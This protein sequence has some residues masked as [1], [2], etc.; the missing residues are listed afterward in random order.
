MY[1]IGYRRHF[2]R[3][4]EWSDGGT[5]ERI[6]RM[7]RVGPRLDRLVLRTPFQRACFRFV[8]ST[9]L[10]S[11]AHRLVL[12]AVIGLALVLASQALMQSFDTAKSLKQLVLSPGVLS[13]PFI[14]TFL[15]ILGLRIV[16]E[17]PVELR[18]NWIFQLMVDAD[19]QESQPLAQKTILLAVLPW[20][21]SI[22]FAS[23]VYLAGIEVALLH[24]MLVLTWAALLTNIA[25]IRF[26]KLPFTC[27]L[28]VFKQHSIVILV[29]LCFGYL[30][31][32]VTTPELESSALAQPLRMLVFLPVALV[33][34]SIPHYL[35]KNTIEIDRKLIFEESATRTVEVLRLSE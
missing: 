35:G 10:R 19:K 6:Y 33:A 13:I 2:V 30:L 11:E 28:P 24:T 25:L 21:L 7:S 23:Y 15:L 27:T 18:S 17:I 1:A 3:I 26:R 5:A 14:L 8:R 16:F 22:T 29:S 4:G 31:Y 20:A 32:A 34:W 12:T 9:L